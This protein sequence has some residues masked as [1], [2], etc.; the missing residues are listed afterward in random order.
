M[1]HHQDWNPRSDESLN[2][3][4]ATYDHMRAKCPVAYSDYLQWSVFRHADVKA[5]LQDHKTFSNRVSRHISV[6]NGMDPPEH[7]VY[8]ELINP[9]FSDQA[10]KA[11]EPT[12][13]IIAK[14]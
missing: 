4:V 1:S 5:I 9:Y 11:F 7:N 2:Q 12:C 14:R 13:Q 8:R 3:A 6:P 10:V